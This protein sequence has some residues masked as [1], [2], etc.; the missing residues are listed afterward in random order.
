MIIDALTTFAWNLSIAASAGG[1]TTIGDQIDLFGL[2]LEEGSTGEQ[3]DIGVHG[4]TI[5]YRVSVGATAL[6][7]AADS[8]AVT[9]ALVTADSADLTSNPVTVD[10]FTVSVNGAGTSHP[11]GTVLREVV[12]P[13]EGP[14]VWKRYV[15]LRR[16]VAT[17]TLDAGTIYAFLQLDTKRWRAY[18]QADI[19][20]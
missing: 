13:A 4:Q 5:S 1:P 11:P 16:T 14:F 8:S 2:G 9:I 6:D 7:A 3:R 18:P 10:T 12:L 17:Q 20:W 15:G 19:G